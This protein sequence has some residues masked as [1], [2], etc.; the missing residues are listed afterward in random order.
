MWYK[1]EQH[2][3]ASGS[4]NLEVILP[5]GETPLADRLLTQAQLNEPELIAPLTLVFCPDSALV[6]IAETVDPEVLFYA[7]YPYFSSVSKSLLQH[8][9][10]SAQELIERRQ[11]TSDSLVVEAASNDG[12]MLK[13]FVEQGI[14]VLGIDPAKAPA[15]AAQKAGIPTMNT[16]FT[17]E[18]AKRLRAEGRAADLFLANNVLAH[19]PDLNGFVAGIRTLLPETGMAVIEAPYVVDLVDHCEF[20]TIYHQHLCYFSVTALDRLFRRHEL[21]LNDV[22]RVSIH[23]GSLRLFI[24]PR[25]NVGE[26]VKALLHEEHARKV[27]TIEYYRDFA[28]RVAD[29][30]RSLTSILHDLK[31][32]GKRIAAYGAAAKATTLLSYCGIDTQLV[33]YVADL[34]PYKHGRYMGGNHLPI[35]PPAQLLEDTPDYVLLLAWNFADEIMRQQEEYRR[36]GGKFIVPIPQPRIV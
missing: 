13:N 21:Y 18:L 31:G 7:E 29:I 19:V 8:F 27:D 9:G 20:D 22:R 12:Y 32:Q 3:R 16:F 5:F 26:S 36:R 15:E 30:R 14:P 2:C 25:E 17:L 1:T 10:A 23:G 33:D 28:E 34:N 4:P 35:V 24:E 6:Q 11:L